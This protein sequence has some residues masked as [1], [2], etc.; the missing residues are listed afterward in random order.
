VTAERRGEEGADQKAPATLTT[1]QIARKARQLATPLLEECAAYELET[2]RA[3][4]EE[5]IETL[6]KE[7]DR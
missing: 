2:K 5:L 1:D 3:L 6:A 4:L 7:L